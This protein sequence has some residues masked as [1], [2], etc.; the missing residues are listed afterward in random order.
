M[1]GLI[2]STVTYVDISHV[3]EN[4]GNAE[5]GPL[6]AGTEACLAAAVIEVQ[7][8]DRQSPTIMYRTW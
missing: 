8:L 3:H 1:A 7:A 5:R 2:V 6:A 4:G